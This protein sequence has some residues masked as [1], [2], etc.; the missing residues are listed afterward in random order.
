MVDL[1]RQ[2]FDGRRN[3]SNI[4]IK[5]TCI[6]SSLRLTQG[7]VDANAQVVGQGEYIAHMRT[8]GEN[9]WCA[10]EHIGN[11]KVVCIPFCRL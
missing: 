4:I 11:L 9:S 1:Q 10:P 3:L 8:S 5:L 2:V 7:G 6:G